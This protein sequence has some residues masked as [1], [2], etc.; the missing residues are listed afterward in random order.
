[1]EKKLLW[2]GFTNN[3][4]W[5]LG[6]A[7]SS[8]EYPDVTFVC[9]DGIQLKAHKVILGAASSVLKS[10]LSER[11][12]DHSFIYLDQTD[13]K[14]VQSLLQ[15]IYTGQC[16][17]S[18]NIY[19]EINFLADNLEIKGVSE[20][21]KN[22]TLLEKEMKNTEDQLQEKVMDTEEQLQGE[23]PNTDI[24][25]EKVS[26]Q[27]ERKRKNDDDLPNFDSLHC[28]RCPNE[29]KSKTAIKNHYRSIHMGVKWECNQCAFQFSLE[30][31]LRT[32]VKSVHEG[33]GTVC[34]LCDYKGRPDNVKTHIL[35][36]HEKVRFNCNECDYSTGTQGGL[37]YH[38]K[39]KH[40]NTTKFDCKE[41]G[42]SCFTQTSLKNHIKFKHEG[43]SYPCSHCNYKAPRENLL[44]RHFKVKHEGFVVIPR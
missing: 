34:K 7:L 31:S 33:S 21:I 16:S 42:E 28:P 37:S 39:T 2:E 43:V 14:V 8:S 40:R 9:N 15:L 20:D 24:K 12:E 35:S 36:V 13:S 19:E 44:T 22:D 29:F 17:S 38:I 27:K 10:I 6:V 11:G 32:H 4:G 3:I 18:L 30:S 5:L 26:F 1:M 23:R 25:E 41:C